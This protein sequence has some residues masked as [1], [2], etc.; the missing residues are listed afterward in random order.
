MRDSWDQKNFDAPDTLFEKLDETNEGKSSTAVDNI[1]RLNLTNIVNMTLMADTKA[2][3][4]ITVSSIVFSVTV[5]NM[6]HEKVAIPLSILGFFSTIALLCAIA[7]IMPR[8]GYPKVPGTKEIDRSSPFFNPLFFGHFSYIPLEE[9]KQEYAKRLTLDSRTYDAIVGD[10]Y[11][12]GRV[13][14]TDKF[15]WLKRS[16]QSFLC[17]ITGAIIS[18][19]FLKPIKSLADFVV[20][21]WFFLVDGF[22]QVLCLVSQR[23]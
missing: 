15:K 10:I 7:V 4:M 23:C 8:T 19:I 21:E 11:G 6:E 13:L 1:L 3:I 14:A 20:I 12:L 16:F 9:F 22:S 17:G 18:Y 2:N 5:A